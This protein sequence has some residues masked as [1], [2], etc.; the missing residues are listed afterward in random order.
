[1]RRPRRRRAFAPTASRTGDVITDMPP[2]TGAIG[3]P[4]GQAVGD[5]VQQRQDSIPAAAGGCATAWAAAGAGAEGR[6]RLS[7]ATS[8]RSFPAA[9]FR[10]P[11]RRSSRPR[12][13]PRAAIQRAPAP[14]IRA[15]DRPMPA[16]PRK[17]GPGPVERQ[18]RPAAVL[19]TSTTGLSRRPSCRIDQE[20]AVSG[21]GYDE[22]AQSARGQESRLAERAGAEPSTGWI[23]R[24][25]STTTRKPASRPTRSRSSSAGSP[26]RLAQERRELE[27]KVG[28]AQADAQV[29]QQNAAFQAKIGR[30]REPFLKE[31]A[32]EKEAVEKVAGLLRNAQGGRRGA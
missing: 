30:E 2:V 25:S 27:A 26:E 22:R 32:T 19:P 17:P 11:C 4:M 16:P 23:G 6:S 12:Q 8:S 29:A 14:R 3:G 31:F 21:T 9:A 18:L 7:P 5:T 28:K 20:Q 1:M 10:K 13:D 24:S 15:A